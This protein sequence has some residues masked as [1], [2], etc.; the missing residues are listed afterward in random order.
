MSNIQFF[1]RQN[2]FF[3]ALCQPYAAEIPF[4]AF[5]LTLNVVSPTV[6]S[7]LIAS[8]RNR[9]VAVFYF[10]LF[11]SLFFLSF[12]AFTVMMIEAALTAAAATVS[13]AAAAR[14]TC[15]MLVGM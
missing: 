13:A 8:E 9:L 14:L 4:P 1:A 6:K 7:R 12:F 5:G 11:L 15:S 3:F 10:I 2:L